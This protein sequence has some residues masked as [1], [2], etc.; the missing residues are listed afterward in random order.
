MS[1]ANP[2]VPAAVAS[3]IICLIL[4]A[5]GGYFGNEIYRNR[6]PADGSSDNPKP[7]LAADAANRPPG[8]G[9]MGGPPMGGP[10][11]P[12]GGPGGPG[13][14]MGGGPGGGMGGMMGGMGGG[15]GM[16]GPPVRSQLA[17]LVSKLDALTNKEKPLLIELSP[18][19]KQKVQEQLKGLAELQEVS[20]DEAKKR[21]DALL[22]VLKDNREKLEAV[23]YRW[24]GA[25]G[26][27]GGGGGFGGF[28]GGGPGGG[29]P[30]GSPPANPFKDDPNVSNAL[31]SLESTLNKGG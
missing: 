22:E 29:R 19:Q 9:G 18:E 11:G 25:A 1:A 12:G 5:A 3:G 14:M 8:A 28:G 2:N 10:G 7:M 20:D 13:G 6:R 4:G 31:K 21:L 23:G 15:R 30:G 17:N 24:P 26:P 27:G 16:Q